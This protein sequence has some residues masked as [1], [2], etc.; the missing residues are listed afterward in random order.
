MIGILLDTET[1]PS[2][3]TTHSRRNPFRL[4]LLLGLLTEADA[5]DT[6]TADVMRAKLDHSQRLL[7]NLAVQDF[8]GLAA[9]AR[10]LVELGRVGGWYALQVPEY[11][12]FL[13][14]FRRS[15]ER[16]GQAAG[17]KNID[18]ATL[19]YHQLTVSC[20]AC[21]KYIRGDATRK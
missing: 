14:E 8:V 2:M 13:T 4:L 7:R 20:V 5:A 15:A 1:T 18:G 9:D 17:E 6:T 19:A 3:N 12:L 21:H 11:D 10:R 16:L